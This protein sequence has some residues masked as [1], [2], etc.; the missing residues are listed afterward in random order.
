MMRMGTAC[1]LTKRGEIRSTGSFDCVQ[2]KLQEVAL[3]YLVK[4]ISL[5]AYKVHTVRK[6]LI[7]GAKML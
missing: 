4:Y 1:I 3:Q 5:Q 2:K 6:E 7:G